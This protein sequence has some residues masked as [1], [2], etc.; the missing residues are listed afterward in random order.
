VAATSELYATPTWAALSGQATVKVPGGPPFVG[1]PGLP[2]VLVSNVT[3]PV[4][5][6]ALPFSAAPVVSVTEA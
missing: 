3:A 1:G 4:R 6:N 2:I 5:A